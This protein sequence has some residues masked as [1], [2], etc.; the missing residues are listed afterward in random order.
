VLERK[1][2]ADYAEFRVLIVSQELE[3]F[4]KNFNNL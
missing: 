1:D 3:R 4:R 2:Q